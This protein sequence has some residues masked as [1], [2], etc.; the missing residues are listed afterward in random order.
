MAIKVFMVIAGDAAG[1]LLTFPRTIQRVDDQKPVPCQAKGFLHLSA[2][3]VPSPWEVWPIARESWN[4]QRAK[5]LGVI[6]VDERQDLVDK[7]SGSFLTHQGNDTE[8]SSTGSAWRP[9]VEQSPSSPQRPPAH[10]CILPYPTSLL[11]PNSPL[12]HIASWHHSLSKL[13]A[14]TSLCQGLLFGGIQTR[15]VNGLKRFS[16]TW[17]HLYFAFTME[18][19]LAG[20]RIL[21][22]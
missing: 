20:Y 13:P 2:W 12:P 15:R 3:V 16:Y 8:M 7:S 11:C 10:P 14:P 21:N 22:S 5:V 19:E 4:C 17:R 1:A 18:G 9:A 6:S